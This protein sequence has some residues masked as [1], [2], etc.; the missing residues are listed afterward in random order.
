MKQ[1]LKKGNKILAESYYENNN[2]AN[3]QPI[4]AAL[5]VST[6]PDE[7]HYRA[8]LHVIVP[9]LTDKPHRFSKPK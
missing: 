2:G 5:I 3:T 1:K 4:S 8:S 9:Y 6:L 7:S